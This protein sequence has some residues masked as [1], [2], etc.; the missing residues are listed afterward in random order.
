MK[1]VLAGSRKVNPDFL[2]DRLETLLSSQ[3][4]P[5]EVHL[6]RG[7]WAPVNPFEAMVEALVNGIAS[8]H[9]GLSVVYHTPHPDDHHPG[10]ASV[11][12]RDIAMVEGADLVLLFFDPQEAVH[13][14]SGTAHLLDKALDAGVRVEAFSVDADGRTTWV[15]GYEPDA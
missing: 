13:G 10:R 4:G 6:R 12:L 14:Y 3:A 7:L 11:Y 5:I 1:L 15:G 8:V 2:R 9:G